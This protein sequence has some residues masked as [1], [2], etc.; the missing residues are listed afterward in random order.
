MLSWRWKVGEWW[1][2]ERSPVATLDRPLGVLRGYFWGYNPR[3][4]DL[5]PQT[6]VRDENKRGDLRNS[7]SVRDC[8]IDLHAD[9]IEMPAKRGSGILF[10][11]RGDSW[12]LLFTHPRLPNTGSERLNMGQDVLQCMPLGDAAGTFSR[13]DGSVSSASFSNGKA[14]SN[15]N[16][17]GTTCR[18]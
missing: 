6:G 7:A 15:E 5:Y 8:E 2:L 4:G 14:S 16:R 3:G 17:R 11:H 1:G 12:L 13:D 18:N 10:P 9:S